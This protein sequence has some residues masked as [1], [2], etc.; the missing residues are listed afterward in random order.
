MDT[1]VLL[2][3]LGANAEF[4]PRSATALREALA[5][6]AIVA[7]EAVWAETAA[8]FPGA[9]EATATLERLRLEYSPLSSESAAHAGQA[10]RA[11]REAGGARR[12]VVADFLVAAHAL[13]QADRLLTRDRGFY[14][15][16][17]ADLTVINPAT[18]G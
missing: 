11:H 7:C 2:D 9:E 4:G 15:L 17:F 6:G 3:V 10:W 18:A 5:Q 12:R 13:H 8:F 14:R 16:C 1:S